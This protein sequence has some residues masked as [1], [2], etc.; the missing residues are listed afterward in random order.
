M[1]WALVG[2][3]AEKL[4]GVRDRLAAID[5]ACAQL[6]LLEA[7]SGDAGSLRAV[8]ERTHVVA[9]TVGPYLN[10]GEPLV[11]ACAETGTDYADLTGEPEFV[12]RMYVRHDATAVATGARLVHACGFDSIPHDLGV[13]F[14]VEQLPEDVPITVRGYVRA[15]GRPSA[16]TLQSAIGQFARLHQTGT[17]YVAR[18]RMEPR[19]PRRVS[20]VRDIVR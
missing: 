1:R 18:R 9:T 13:L 8:A 7:D 4:A 14:T 11:A 10:L 19:S 3:S 17:A 12:D 16:G 5:P 2:R 6:E 20:S 15:G